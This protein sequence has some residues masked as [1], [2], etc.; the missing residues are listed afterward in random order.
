M[1]VFTSKFS[2]SSFLAGTVIAVT[3]SGTSHA[4]ANL[5]LC[6]EDKDQSPYVIGA[7]GLASNPGIAVEI[8]QKAAERVGASTKII[9]A[10]WK[11]CLSILE[12]GE[13][14]GVFLGSYK[15]ER[16]KFGAFPMAGGN[17]DPSRR[18]SM[19][20]Y[21]LYRLKGGSA[22]WDGKAFSGIDGKVGAPLGYSI[23]K[24]LEKKGL[25]MEESKGTETDFKKLSSKRIVAAAALTNVGDA[26]IESGAFPNI[27]KVE[28]PLVSKPYY[29]LLSKQLM[30]AEKD[31][32][33]KFWNEI[34]SIRDADGK[35][36]A[37]KYN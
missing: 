25:K 31:M 23:V 14:D 4:A 26:L 27:E 36:L 16:E 12:K 11:R 3:M 33:E 8:I 32:A 5:T 13:V 29:L 19:S 20:S 37:K 30:K 24:D 1:T 17:V 22:S 9:R 35:A 18:V 28:T 21:S 34:A 15:K 10:P 7:S 2:F 6:T